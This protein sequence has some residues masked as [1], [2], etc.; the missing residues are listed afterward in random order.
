MRDTVSNPYGQ[1]RARMCVGV[2]WGVV[3]TGKRTDAVAKTW[4]TKPATR[5]I[6]NTPDAELYRYGV[7]APE[8]WANVTVAPGTYVVRLKFAERRD[9]ADPKRRP[10]SVRISGRDVVQSLDLAAKAGGF[11]KAV[12][13]VF[14]EIRPKNGIVEIRFTGA[15]GGEAIVQAIEV[16][17]SG[18]VASREK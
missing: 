9:Q 3:R 5:P 13:L 16:I 12:D 15:D 6:S 2:S 10:M 8:F 18:D 11:H 7:H 17:P 1:W 4:W 14:D